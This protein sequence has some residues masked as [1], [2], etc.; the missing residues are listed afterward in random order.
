MLLFFACLISPSKT[1]RWIYFIVCLYLLNRT[2]LPDPGSEGYEELQKYAQKHADEIERS[3][4]YQHRIAKELTDGDEELQYSAV[5]RGA[6]AALSHRLQEANT[7]SGK[8]V[9]AL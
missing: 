4:S 2:K 5:H 9:Y 6:D 3:E 7:N 1:R 8:N